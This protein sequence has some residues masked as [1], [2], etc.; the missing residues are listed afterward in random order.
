MSGVESTS[1]PP[2]PERAWRQWVKPAVRPRPI[3][4]AA[5][6]DS[7]L[8]RAQRHPTAPA[9]VSRCARPWARWRRKGKSFVW[10]QRRCLL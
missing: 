6:L 3:S 9:A 1:M 5:P 2:T 7:N 8:L 4:S 10:I